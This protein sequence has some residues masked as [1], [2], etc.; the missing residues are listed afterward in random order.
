MEACE[1]PPVSGSG[2]LWSSTPIVQGHK[3]LAIVSVNRPRAQCPHRSSNRV[4]ERKATSAYRGRVG[5]RAVEALTWR[6]HHQRIGRNRG[7]D[8]RGIFGGSSVGP[9]STTGFGPLSA[10][11]ICGGRVS[12]WG[13]AIALVDSGAAEVPGSSG[14]LGSSVNRWSEPIGCYRGRNL[15]NVVTG[16]H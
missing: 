13:H 2:R 7:T 16:Q 6:R 4:K 12:Q 5:Q 9:R 3:A 10:Q 11:R 8:P 1:L 15:R 14:F